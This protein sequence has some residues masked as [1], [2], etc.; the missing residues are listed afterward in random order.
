M[1]P[2]TDHLLL[3]HLTLIVR[4][5]VDELKEMDGHALI[6][7]LVSGVTKKNQLTRSCTVLKTYLIRDKNKFR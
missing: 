5:F 4:V 1:L 7:G 2:S 6:C 3:F